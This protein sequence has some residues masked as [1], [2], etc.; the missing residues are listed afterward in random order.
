M[1]FYYKLI[2][3]REVVCL[4]SLL[5]DWYRTLFLLGNLVYRLI[6][7][8]EWVWPQ[9]RNLCGV[10][11]FEKIVSLLSQAICSSESVI[12]GSSTMIGDC[13]NVSSSQH[14]Q[15]L[16]WIRTCDPTNIVWSTRSRSWWPPLLCWGRPWTHSQEDDDVVKMD[17]VWV[18]WAHQRGMRRLAGGGLEPAVAVHPG[19]ITISW[20]SHYVYMPSLATHHFSIK[21]DKRQGRAW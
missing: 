19:A 8:E 14:L 11:W 13:V 20:C 18:W 7:D 12:N 16:V 2:F 5:I 21:K 1:F 10:A 6:S 3:V 4:C 17:V 9:K 15:D